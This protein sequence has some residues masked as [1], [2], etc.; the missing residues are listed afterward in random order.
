MKYV[1]KN[2][3]KLFGIFLLSV[4]FYG[5]IASFF[6]STVHV[7]V[8]EELYLSLAKSFHYNGRFELQNELT[9]YNCVFYSIL[10]SFAYYFYS[11]TRILLI[12]RWMG[13]IMMCSSAFP[14][15]LLACNILKD[16]KKALIVTSVMMLMPYMF[17]C[18]YIMQEVLNYP[19]FLW[20]LYLIYCYFKMSNIDKVKSKI[21]I[22]ASAIISALCFFTKTYTMF[23]PAMV[24]IWFIFK[25][26]SNNRSKSYFM[27]MLLF[28]LIYI[29]IVALGYLGIYAINDFELGNNHYSSQFSA[30]FPITFK[31]VKAAII[32]SLIYFSL[33]LLNMGAYPVLGNVVC[34]KKWKGADKDFFLLCIIGI[35]LL[36][37]EIVILIVLTE[38]GIMTLPHKFL[39]RYFQIFVP[40]IL[41][42]Y[43]K[44]KM[45]EKIYKNKVTG[46][47]LLASIIISCVYLY[48]LNGTSRQAIMDGYLYLTAINMGKY[49]LPYGDVLCI[50]WGGVSIA[51]GGKIYLNQNKRKIIERGA[52]IFL[53][54]FW[55]LNLIQLPL[56]TN[57]I[58]G[59][60]EI[61]EDSIKIAEYINS[62]DLNDIYYVNGKNEDNYLRN[63][64]G[65]LKQGYQ[66]IEED[67]LLELSS[68]EA[69]SIA[70]IA[71]A[72]YEMELNQLK[73]VELNGSKLSLYTM[74]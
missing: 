33:Y 32:Y 8:D 71:P 72:G 54:L 22:S 17:N 12:M 23:I 20:F 25:Y 10:L 51:V 9:N 64:H 7:D 21:Y 42:L 60:K 67:D 59:G 53:I 11:P 40:P 63:F 18:C 57:R 29:V 47:A 3:V 39:F 13:V 24:N 62:G 48:I 52:L 70:V 30:L 14:I 6:T 5:M 43:Q 56:Y 68:R 4:I 61:Q 65:Y 66:V 19:L 46:A 28:D 37:E 36:I 69:E 27:Q 49:I 73:K 35:P 1:N 50:A 26:F 45:E 38:E 34:H 15:W 2:I 16:R 74:L 31:T 58:A 55:T 44:I 41:L